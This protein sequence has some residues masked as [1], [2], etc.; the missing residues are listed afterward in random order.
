MQLTIDR[1]E[2]T[3]AFPGAPRL[4]YFDIAAKEEQD[5]GDIIEHAAKLPAAGYKIERKQLE[6]KTGYVLEDVEIRAASDPTELAHRARP[7]LN[8][9]AV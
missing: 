4:A 5:I 9:R 3:A 1:F 7:A 6:D 8:G 2:L